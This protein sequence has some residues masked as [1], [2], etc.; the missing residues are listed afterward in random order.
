M[1]GLGLRFEDRSS[2]VTAGVECGEV[3][4]GA[5]EIG[6]DGAGEGAEVGGDGFHLQ[7]LASRGL[8]G[9]AG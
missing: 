2:E 7:Y 6:F 8:S 3:C 4:G 5:A 9:S 1:G